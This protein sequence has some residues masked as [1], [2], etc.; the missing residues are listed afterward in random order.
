M[1]ILII[2]GPNLNLLGERNPDQYGN[3]SLSDLNSEIS[4]RYN[5]KH[6]LKF[7]QS[8]HE[9]EI[10]DFLHEYRNW[11]D[12]A[13]INPGALTHYS[14]SLRDAIESIQLPCVE[15]HLSDIEKREDFRKISVTA[16]VCIKQVKGKGFDSYFEG[17]E[18]LTKS[19]NRV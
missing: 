4:G 17:I 9:G 16:P 12:G 1:N 2:H 3:R 8:N 5:K 10:I 13:V 6:D 11:G 19:R 18:Y 15:V 14:Y 7:F